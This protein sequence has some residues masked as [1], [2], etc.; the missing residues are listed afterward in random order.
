MP[1]TPG[2]VVYTLVAVVLTAATC[3]TV[4]WLVIQRRDDSGNK[5]GRT[6]ASID[7][8][9]CDSCGRRRSAQVSKQ[10]LRMTRNAERLR[11][12]ETDLIRKVYELDETDPPTARLIAELQICS[13]RMR[14]QLNELDDSVEAVSAP[15]T[16]PVPPASN[17]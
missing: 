14:A 6:R 11:R 7:G 4:A 9:I 13:N 17:N 8:D 15:P 1:A 10:I 12:V 2:S 5:N 3:L 16:L